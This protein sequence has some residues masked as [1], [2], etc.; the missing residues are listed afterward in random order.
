[1]DLDEST[2]GI[3]PEAPLLSREFLILAASTMLFFG[4]MGA[5]NPVL[6]RF[7]SGEL[8]ASDAMVG[9]VVGSFAVASLLFRPFLGRLGDHRGARLLM[10]IGCLAGAVGMLTMLAVTSPAAAIIGRLPHG[11][12]QAAV[13]TGSTTLAID[14]A[15]VYR[16][17]EAASYILVAFHLGL[18]TGPLLGEFVLDRWSYA[19]VWVVL[20]MLMVAGACVAMLLPHRG[21]LHNEP[22]SALLHRNGFLPG[23]IIGLA[24]MGPIS[25]SIFVVLY[26]EEIGLDRVAPVFLATSATVAIVRI[27]AGRVPDHLGPLRNTTVAC[28]IAIAGSLV[29]AAWHSPLGL[30]VGVVVISVGAALIMPGLVPVAVHGVEDHRR[31]SALATFTMFLDVSVALTGPLFGLIASG[32]GYRA[33]FVAGA[34][35]SL[36]ALV[37]TRL[38]LP[39]RVAGHTDLESRQANRTATSD[40]AETAG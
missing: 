2:R 3:A 37:M 4:A 26:A 39:A 29:L 5:A 10:V 25:L 21:K 20:A 24:M 27:F 32:I 14:L 17:G 15:P 9:L 16:R 31:A 19:G 28:S 36:I 13:M 22:R 1:M 8:G 18:G 38:L 33:V 6:P 30:F 23:A 35:T 34:F 7:I 11:L 40:S 12:A